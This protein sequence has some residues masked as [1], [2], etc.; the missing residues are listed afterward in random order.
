MVFFRYNSVEELG[1]KVQF[2]ESNLKGL[3]LYKTAEFRYDFS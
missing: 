3:E 1:H 2:D